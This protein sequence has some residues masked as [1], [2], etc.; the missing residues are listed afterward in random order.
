MKKILLAFLLSA[1]VTSCAVRQVPLSDK[2]FQSHAVNYKKIL[3]DNLA[4]ESKIN[5]NDIVY[6][7]G[8]APAHLGFK[9]P[10]HEA[11]VNK[12]KNSIVANG[13]NDHL[14]ISIIRVG[15]FYEKNVA[16]DVVFVGLF[17]VGR[18]RG[19]KCD[20]EV[21]IKNSNESKRLTL[22][23]QIRRPH[24][25]DKEE[26]QSFIETCQSE[27]VKSLAENIDNLSL[28][29]TKATN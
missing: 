17:M 29:K 13:E 22:V 4:V 16:D 5:T 20:A 15:Y 8:W 27:L 2:A 21:N 6:V 11:F 26:L 3:V 10:L 1:F 19:F 24:F 28:N 12:V 9:P 23:H 7:N 18:E 14:D 25:K